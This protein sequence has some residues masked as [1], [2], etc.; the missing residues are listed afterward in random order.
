[1]LCAPASLMLSQLA[2]HTRCDVLVTLAAAMDQ[3]V[4]RNLVRP[5]TRLDLFSNPLVLAGTPN[6]PVANA[7][8]AVTDDTPASGLDGRAVLA[9]NGLSPRVIKG[10][11]NTDDVAFLVRLGAADLGLMYATDA[12]AHPSLH[13]TAT[14]Q[15]NPALTRF[16][17]AQNAKAASPDAQ[18]F[19]A[20]LRS[21]AA[22]QTLSNAGLMV[23]A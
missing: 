5:A 12:N 13:I 1:M 6:M 20:L 22:A 8:V 4:Q 17:A 16:A 18:K 14:L 11:A 9:A 19:L 2:R 10:V 15:A 21:P 7:V 3:A 23:S